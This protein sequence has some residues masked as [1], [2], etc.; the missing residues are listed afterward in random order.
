MV[1]AGSPEDAQPRSYTANNGCA[2]ERRNRGAGAVLAA[3]VVRGN[4][5]ART[6]AAGREPRRGGGRRRDGSGSGG[7]A[8][9]RG[10]GKADAH[11]SRL[12]GAI[13]PAAADAVRRGGC[14]RVAAQGRGCA[15]APGADQFKCARGGEDRRPGAGE[16]GRSASRSRCG[17]GRDRQLRDPL[18]DQRPLRARGFAVDLRRRGGSV[19]RDD[20]YS[21]KSG[22]RAQGPGFRRRIRSISSSAF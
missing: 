13:E 19:C 1:A 21:A 4:R 9:S 5:R 6:A 11:R 17:A 2:C 7:I 20:E 12:R 22:A 16:C 15:A 18:P 3:G 14:A 8:G 10:R